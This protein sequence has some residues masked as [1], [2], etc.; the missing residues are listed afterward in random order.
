L[1]PGATLIITG[2]AKG[3]TTLAKERALIVERFLL[4]QIKVHVTLKTIVS[5]PSNRVTVTTTRL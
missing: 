4:G 2:Y 1:K 3:N 5:S